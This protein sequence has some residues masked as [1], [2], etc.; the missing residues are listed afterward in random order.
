MNDKNYLLLGLMGMVSIL[1][2]T[3]GTKNPS[4]QSENGIQLFQSRF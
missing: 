2:S 1:G 4:F 3:A